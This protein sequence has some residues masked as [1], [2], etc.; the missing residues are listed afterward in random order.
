MQA[1]RSKPLD[2]TAIRKFIRALID[3]NKR[4]VSKRERII[5]AFQKEN[6]KQQ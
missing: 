3:K 1:I 6:K 5:K 4:N 2:L